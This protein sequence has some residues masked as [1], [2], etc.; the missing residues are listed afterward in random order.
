MWLSIA[1]VVM[2]WMAGSLVDSTKVQEL[3]SCFISHIFIAQKILSRLG[4]YVASV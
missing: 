3:P 1:F 4:P 2:L